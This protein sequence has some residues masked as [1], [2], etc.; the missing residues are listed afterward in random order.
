MFRPNTRFVQTVADA[1]L[2]LSE[3]RRPSSSVFRYFLR[4]RNLH[5]EERNA[6]NLRFSNGSVRQQEHVTMH[7]NPVLF[8]L[9]G[10]LSFGGPALH[11][12]GLA[13]D[14]LTDSAGLPAFSHPPS[15]PP[16]AP[17]RASGKRQIIGR[18][19]RRATPL[20]VRGRRPRVAR[21]GS[22]IISGRFLEFAHTLRRNL[23]VPGSLNARTRRMFH[24]ERQSQAIS[25]KYQILRQFSKIYGAVSKIS[26]QKVIF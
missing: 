24:N 5:R 3:T 22:G 20:R 10:Q 1:Y 9:L 17:A 13:L 15:S 7:S 18:E 23:G 8:V 6:A 26:V 2:P 25:R 14:R 11:C 12:C 4:Q 16:P 19:Y 21:Q